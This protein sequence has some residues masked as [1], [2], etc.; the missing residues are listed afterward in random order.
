MA[1][2]NKALADLRRLEG[3]YSNHAKDVGG[4]TAFGIAEAYW[5]QYWAEWDDMPT[6][7]DA[8][9]FYL[10]EFWIPLKLEGLHDQNIANEVFEQAVNL[11]HKRAIRFWQVALCLVKGAGAATIDGRV[12][13]QTLN[14]TNHLNAA[15]ALRVS[16]VLNGIQFM[17]YIYRTNS[18]DDVMAL[19]KTMPKDDQKVF[20]RGWLKRI[21]FSA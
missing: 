2:A 12:G 5:P 19:F 14:A 6:W 11:G 20:F 8:E 13:P 21:D 7:A 16:K 1:R 18:L 17:Y 15:D 9:Q 4:R 3:Y 10:K